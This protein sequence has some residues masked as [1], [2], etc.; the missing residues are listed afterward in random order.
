M[1]L[2]AQQGE[3]RHNQHPRSLHAFIFSPCGLRPAG[4]VLGS[5]QMSPETP[6]SLDDLRYPVGRSPLPASSSVTPAERAEA[7]AVLAEFPQQLRNAVSG[8]SHKQ[9][10]TPYREGGWTLAQVVHHLGDSHPTALFRYKLALTLDWPTRIV[11]P[12]AAFAQLHDS[13]AAPIECSLEIVEATHA[14]WVMLLQ[15][16]TGEQWQRGF[17]H[18]ERG[19]MTLEA[20]LMRYSW[21]SRHHLAH[22]THLRAAH[23]W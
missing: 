10:E 11:Y 5:T 1:A 3:R 9:L 17:I 8:L 23:G 12:E 20:N 16:M 13:L 14:R 18:P 2:T 22:I 15:S 6:S 21:H 19:P 7:I 4:S